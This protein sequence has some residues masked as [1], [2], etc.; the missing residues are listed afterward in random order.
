MEEK[1]SATNINPPGGSWSSRKRS[2]WRILGALF[3]KQFLI[4]FRK[5]S[6]L[7]EFTGSCIIY[8]LLVPCY[9]FTCIDHPAQIYPEINY[10][11]L[12]PMDLFIFL[13]TTANPTL[14]IAPDC[15]RT[16]S[17]FDILLNITKEFLPTNITLFGV[18]V[19]TSDEMKDRIYL[20]EQN[21][22]G[23]YWKNANDE[24]ATT[25]PEIELYRQSLFGT[26]D[27]DIFEILRRCIALENGDLDM[28]TFNLSDQAF[29]STESKEYFA[30]DFLVVLFA[31]FPGILALMPDFQTVLDEKDTKVATL[32]FFMGCP[33]TA[34]WFVSFITPVI[35]ATIPYLCMCICFCYFFIMV[36]TSLSLLWFVSMA[37]VISHTVFQ[38]FLSTFMKNASQG[39]STIIVFL[40][41][42]VFFCYL[43]YFYTLDPKNTN[44][45]VKH[46]FSI[47]PLSAYQMTVMAMYNQT[48]LGFPGEQ[49]SDVTLET[50][51]PIYLGLEW[52]FGD[53]LVYFLLFVLFNLTNAREFGTPLIRWRDIFKPSAW[54]RAF[55]R[56]KDDGAIVV[57][58]EGVFLSVDNLSK[59]YHGLRTFQAL[60]DVNFEINCGEVI[61]IIGPNG[62]GK[63]TLLNSLA[64]AIEP[65]TGT[66][67]I[68]EGTPT[69][70]FSEL[71]KYLGVCFQ[72]NVLIG[73]LTIRENFHFFGAFRGIDKNFLD[74]SISFFGETL[75]LTEML[76]QRAENLS[77]GQKRKLCI[78]LS[79]LGNPPLV[80]MDEP[81]AAVDVQA[82]QLIWKTI[83]SLKN[84]TCIV[85]SHA[86]EEAEAVSSRLFIVA[87]GHL[88]FSGTSTQLRNEFKCGYLLRIERE[89]GT[90]GPVLDLAQSFVPEAKISD[91]RPDTIAMPVDD[92]IPE[93]LVEMEKQKDKLGI[94]SYSFTVEQL[95]D[96]LLK[97]II[98]EEAANEPNIY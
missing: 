15:S 18:Y 38:L 69:N 6:D 21:G 37:F 40:V 32:S 84:T 64:G 5:A 54:K 25:S 93:F 98:N 51:Y 39:R 53:A 77:G 20:S 4:K 61:V 83:S 11:S 86:L 58:N 17:L 42:T 24:D 27:K 28:V 52:L 12:V 87:S 45:Y 92:I 65:T 7:I 74:E 3:K 1:L 47:L 56:K 62:A 16:R 73:Q 79:L 48:N 76:D 91:E 96:M 97:L 55:G 59:T 78:A 50:S 88:K 41:F 35:I 94:I 10:T 72:E 9:I 34:Y 43:H 95:E 26:P 67:S 2:I 80:I 44:H 70:H 33:E 75:Q 8:F 60:S 36:G 66:M 46:I 14:V 23:I 89:D 13:G 19:N 22:L 82:R 85:T 31:V 81:T 49:W 63:S 71:H 30:I 29:A 90:V 68:F 57:K